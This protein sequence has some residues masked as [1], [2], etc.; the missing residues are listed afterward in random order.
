MQ[1]KSVR[2]LKT[3]GYP[4]NLVIDKNGNFYD[5][6]SG[7]FPEIGHQISNSIQNALEEK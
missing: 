6:I 4:T 1:K 2:C 5:Y 7:G 3:S